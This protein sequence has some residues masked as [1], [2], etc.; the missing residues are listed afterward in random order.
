MKSKKK[1]TRPE[2]RAF[3]EKTIDEL[4]EIVPL[5]KTYRL[6]FNDKQRANHNNGFLTVTHHDA[7][8]QADFVVYADVYDAPRGEIL[9][10]LC[11]EMGHCYLTPFTRD[12]DDKMNEI[13]ERIATEIGH[14]ICTL[15]QRK[16]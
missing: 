9:W 15:Y 7:M 10:G 2:V 11:H 4:M 12:D 14:L 5:V 8:Y 1:M 6:R 16:K 13:E 3:V